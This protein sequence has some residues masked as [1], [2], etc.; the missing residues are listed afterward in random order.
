MV[1]MLF[2]MMYVLQDDALFVLA[3][4]LIKIDAGEDV[5]KWDCDMYSLRDEYIVKI[6]LHRSL[7]SIA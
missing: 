1:S 6:L 2:G 4:G 5:T 3:E 7:A